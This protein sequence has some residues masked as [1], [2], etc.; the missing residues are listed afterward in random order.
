[1]FEALARI[2]GLRYVLPY[3][4]CPSHR[5]NRKADI[6]RRIVHTEGQSPVKCWLPFD[7]ASEEERVTSLNPS[8]LLWIF[9]R[10]LL[11]SHSLNN[12]SSLHSET[13]FLHRRVQQ[14][15][16]AAE[17]ES[18]IQNTT[19]G[20]SS[21]T[22]TSRSETACPSSPDKCS[23]NQSQQREEESRTRATKH[24]TRYSNH[25]EQYFLLTCHFPL[26]M[27]SLFNSDLHNPHQHLPPLSL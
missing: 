6:S 24:I 12:A 25:R 7:Q 5:T 16:N 11:S 8:S 19:H 20:S 23:S 18:R 27:K 14:Q 1:M 26:S 2:S 21:L 3:T 22:V 13:H 17:R 4:C 10:S 9:A 15:S